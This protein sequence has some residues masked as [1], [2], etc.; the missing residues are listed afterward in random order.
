MQKNVKL[1]FPIDYVTGDKLKGDD[2]KIGYA[3]DETGIP[4]G[5]MGLD[6]GAKV[7]LFAFATSC[8][9]FRL[10][11]APLDPPLLHRYQ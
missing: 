10:S 6:I 7:L 3:T 5:L 2:V 8:T 1:H 9:R 11:W 4:D